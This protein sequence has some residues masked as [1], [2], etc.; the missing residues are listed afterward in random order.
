MP[1]L[2]SGPN[3]KNMARARSILFTDLP[4][5]ALRVLHR[6]DSA[7]SALSILHSAAFQGYGLELTNGTNNN[8]GTLPKA[9]RGK[10]K[11]KYLDYLRNE[12]GMEGLHKFLSTFVSS[13][14]ERALRDS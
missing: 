2:D 5:E 6:N 10:M 4:S 1:P 7:A 8:K 3:E 9:S 14:V 12:K 13:L 11:Y